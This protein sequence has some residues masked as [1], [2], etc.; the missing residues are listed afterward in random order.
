MANDS[1]PI[2]GQNFIKF[3][4]QQTLCKELTS[5][6]SP[7]LSASN[8]QLS[9]T[10]QLL[11]SLCIVCS[12]DSSHSTPPASRATRAP[13]TPSTTSK[14][15]IFDKLVAKSNREVSQKSVPPSSASHVTRLG[16]SWVRTGG[17]RG[18]RHDGQPSP[19]CYA[20]PSSSPS[21]S[22]S[23]SSPSSSL[24]KAA[25]LN[26]WPPASSTAPLS[27]CSRWPLFHMPRSNSNICCFSSFIGDVS[28]S[29][30][31][32][33]FGRTFTFDKCT[34]CS[35]FTF[36]LISCKKCIGPP[37]SFSRPISFTGSLNKQSSLLCRHQ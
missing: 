37:Y 24:T 19:R 32:Y 33:H 27:C 2:S 13:T 11:K 5:S 31:Q 6:F 17:A 16:G 1:T 25:S 30:W 34:C 12:P 10:A 23:L 9:S 18:V 4:P 26:M 22:Q 21:Y 15:C 3:C 20:S 7:S 35:L 14:S 29:C 8:L 28:L 36:Y